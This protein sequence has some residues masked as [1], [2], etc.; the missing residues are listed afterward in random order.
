MDGKFDGRTTDHAA[1]STP[2]ANTKYFGTSHRST[3]VDNNHLILKGRFYFDD[4]AMND[5]RRDVGSVHQKDLLR[6]VIF[7]D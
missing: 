7:V 1:T 4:V 6:I 3:M 2:F 5:H